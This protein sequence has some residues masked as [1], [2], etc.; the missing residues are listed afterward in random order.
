[1]IVEGDR[2][3]LENVK[4]F[5][6]TSRR[7]EGEGNSNG[8]RASTAQTL[9]EAAKPTFRLKKS[10]KR[11]AGARIV[12]NKVRIQEAPGL[13]RRAAPAEQWCFPL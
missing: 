8:D 10:I 4:D 5:F 3:R 9:F 6:V 1:M 12:T 7:S 11:L 13:S 2:I